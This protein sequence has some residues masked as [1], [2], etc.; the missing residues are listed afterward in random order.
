MSSN[1]GSRKAL[2]SKYLKSFECRIQDDDKY[3]IKEKRP[4][5]IK[6]IEKINSDVEILALS[7]CIDNYIPLSSK[8]NELWYLVSY[9]SLV[10]NGVKEVKKIFKA[11]DLNEYESAIKRLKVSSFTSEVWSVDHSKVS[12]NERLSN[13]KGKLTFDQTRKILNVVNAFGLDFYNNDLEPDYSLL[14][15]NHLG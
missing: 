10:V 8:Y 4:D 1:L 13:W 9:E 15:N 14:Y 3:F 11:L 6:F 7:W 12:I 2:V 5:L